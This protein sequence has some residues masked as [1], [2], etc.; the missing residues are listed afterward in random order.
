MDGVPQEH[1]DEPMQELFFKDMLTPE[2][3]YKEKMEDEVAAA[4][5]MDKY[6]SEAQWE[7]LD[8]LDSSIKSL[9]TRRDS[10]AKGLLQIENN[11]AIRWKDAPYARW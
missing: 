9:R 5:G 7:N 6:R 3:A 10:Q 1:V 2:K 8:R 11:K 4:Y